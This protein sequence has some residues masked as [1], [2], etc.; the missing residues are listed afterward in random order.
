MIVTCE[1]LSPTCPAAHAVSSQIAP[2]ATA[3]STR[4]P[5][6]SSMKVAH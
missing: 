2:S 6:F 1:I 3:L 4:L 5:S